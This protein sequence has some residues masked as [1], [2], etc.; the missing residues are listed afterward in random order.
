MTK[1]DLFS[2][3]IKIFGL[4]TIVV[5]LFSEGHWELFLL[6]SHIFH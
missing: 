3:L 5:T 6:Y 4:L 2:V 1:R